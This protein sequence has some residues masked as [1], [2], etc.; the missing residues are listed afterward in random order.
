MSRIAEWLNHQYPH[1][2]SLS[3]IKRDGRGIHHPITGMLLCPIRY[4]WDDEEY[5][6]CFSSIRSCSSIDSRARTKLHEAD[7]DFDYTI[8]I[9]LRCFYHS[10]N[11]SIDYPEKG[12]LK[13]SLLVKVNCM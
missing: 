4:D 6:S 3:T 9:C 11:G 7:P 8:D 12:F 10:F 13:S 5:V 1:E 2:P